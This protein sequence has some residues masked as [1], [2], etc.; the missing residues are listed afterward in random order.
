M[1]ITWTAKGVAKALGIFLLLSAG[2]ALVVAGASVGIDA[3]MPGKGYG[4]YLKSL[5]L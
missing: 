4:A 1:Q 5:F 2:A 3:A